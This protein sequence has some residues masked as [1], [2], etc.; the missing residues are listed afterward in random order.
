MGS[1]GSKGA[2][3]GGHGSGWQPGTP[4]Q[5]RKYSKSGHD[6]TP[7][8]TEERIAAAK[9]LT[10]FQRH[11]T[12]QVGAAFWSVLCTW[13]AAAALQ[14]DVG[15]SEVCSGGRAVSHVAAPLGCLQFALR[16]LA[17]RAGGN[18]VLG[19]ILLQPLP[20]RDTTLS[21]PPTR[22]RGR[23]RLARS[24]HSPGR[25]W[26]AARM[27]TSA[28]ASMSAPWAACRSSAQVGWQGAAV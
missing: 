2:Q 23:R 19:R 10:D 3:Q 9:P 12:L 16:L 6:I 15:G 5:E 22:P 20:T 17:S 13:P 7:L 24:A 14:G 28:R 4:G 26:T 18:V 27:T 1:S 25:L 21:T 11:V 8:T